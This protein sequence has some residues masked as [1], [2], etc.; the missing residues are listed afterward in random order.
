MDSLEIDMELLRR[1]GEVRSTL[2]AAAEGAHDR[3][4]AVQNAL[5]SAHTQAAAGTPEA[6]AALATLLSVV[7]DV[8]W[9]D[10]E[11]AGRFTAAALGTLE[12][13]EQRLFAPQDPSAEDALRQACAAVAE[14]GGSRV[15]APSDGLPGDGPAES[16]LNDV[17][18][19]LVQMDPE[20]R[21]Q[22]STLEELLRGTSAEAAVPEPVRSIL[23]EAVD[24]LVPVTTPTRV[25]KAV[26]REAVARVG[27]LIERA[28]LA[29]EDVE[30]AAQTD[31]P[32]AEAA[33]E[34]V[35]FDEPDVP[36]ASEDA[37][38]PASVREA[39][40]PASADPDL[41]ADFITEGLEYLDQAEEALLALEAAPD[42]AESVNVVF[43]AFHTIKGVAGF[44]ELGLVTEMAHHAETVFSE[45]R[46][47]TLVY[48]G[49]VADLALR[50]SDVL[51]ALLHN[52]AYA[53][54]HEVNIDVPA[55]YTPL[56]STLTDPGLM[57]RLASGAPADESRNGPGPDDTGTSNDEADPEPGHPAGRKEPAGQ[58]AS[59]GEASVRVRT[60]RLDRLVDMVGELVIAHTM[61]AQDRVILSDRGDLAK[62]VAHSAKILRELQDLSTSLRMVPLKPA[63]RKVSRVVRDLGR[64]SGKPVRFLSE[65]EDTEI[66][67]TMVDVITDPLVHMVRNSVDH[68]IE[69]PDEREKL[70]KPREG[71]VRIQAYQAGGTVMVE[72]S[73][74][75]RG[76]DRE[77]ILAKARE[78]GLID[79]ERGMTDSEIFGL[80][81]AAGFST[82]DRVTEV[83]GRGVGMDVVRRNVESLRGRV[84]VESE[85]GVG[86][87]FRIQLPL[88]LAITEGMLTRVGDE[89]YIIPSVKIQRSLRPQPS[90]LSTVNGR[91]E[92]VMLQDDLIP[93]IR[94]HRLFDIP[95]AVEEPTEALLV[96]IGEGT[97]RAAL[98]V[99][100]LVAQQQFVVKALGGIVANTK[101]IAGGAILGNGE[102]GLILD[103]E[104]LVS[105]ARGEARSAA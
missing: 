101:G 53:M 100:E 23:D 45:V 87:T 61:L 58:T 89:R 76:L 6:E 73:D 24:I 51:K 49:S 55:G 13:I 84:T 95:G 72:I 3:S 86:S 44:L 97:Q 50:T 99:D 16:L 26:R 67:R 60:D 19:F 32:T 93:I 57:D 1:I 94:L 88:T 98:L 77:K 104:G 25:R 21:R 65:G 14:C 2:D 36:T 11:A 64:K 59:A 42:D 66:D 92:M 71:T 40:L 81:F 37:S 39:P 46:D 63:F 31:E 54:E 80:I 28:V 22:T 34:P 29:L 30:A 74:D 10:P 79:G 4:E 17:A 75:G 33:A 62:K 35:D 8:A 7:P 69:P 70:G 68:G 105:L 27:E 18:S 85:P 56:L 43:R 12:A 5:S 91:A 103:P 20:D 90:A 102:V 52:V 82:A 47:G 38:S 96:V 48:S 9:D 41:L 15:P 78:R 83:S